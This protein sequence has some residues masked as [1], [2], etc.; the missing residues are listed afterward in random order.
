[1]KQI[2][3]GKIR[4]RPRWYFVTGSILMFL[5]FVGLTFLATFLTN[6]TF[7][8]IRRH[9]PM[10]QWRLSL[11]LDSFPWWVP[12][13]AV[14]AVAAGIRL[15]KRYDFSYRKNFF[16]IVIFFIAVTIVA[17]ALIDRFGFNEVWQRRGPM[18]RF[19]QQVEP[20][21]NNW[22]RSIYINRNKIERW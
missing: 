19:Y 22:Y 13:L 1:M 6:L 10:G 5:G 2:N 3:T 4:M 8:F 20:D 18:R 16:W 12:F 9:G 7:F 14:I 17:A 21:R 15:L 11:M